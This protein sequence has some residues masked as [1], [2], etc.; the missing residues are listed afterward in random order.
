MEYIIPAFIGIGL[1]AACGFRVF[2]PPFVMSVASHLGFEAFQFGGSFE[3]I[4]SWPATIALGI[5]VGVEIAAYY[6]PW[7]D[8][9]LDTVTTPMAVVAGTMATGA[10]L[11]DVDPAIKWAL[12]LIAG[13]GSAA[14]IQTGTGITRA[15]S[16]AA[17]GGVGNPVVS[18]VEAGGSLFLSILAIVLPIVAF[19]VVLVMVVWSGKKMFGWFRKKPSPAE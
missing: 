17:T 15:A 7:V 11:G 14:V 16:T 1:S 13:G 8:N 5:A 18:T 2:V 3:W 10:M 12:A 9:L 19:V 4:G 6:I